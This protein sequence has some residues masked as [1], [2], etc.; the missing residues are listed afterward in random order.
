MR[1]VGRLSILLALAVIPAGCGAAKRPYAADPLFR[2]GNAV[3][4]D[5]D[6]ARGRDFQPH[7]EPDP[8]RAP[9]IPLPR[10]PEWEWAVE[11]TAP[12][13]TAQAE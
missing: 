6:R 2:H 13:V 1:R 9:H 12:P 3:W 8:P 4:G 10:T 11:P 7:A 5:A